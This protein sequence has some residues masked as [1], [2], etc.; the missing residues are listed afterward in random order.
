MDKIRRKEEKRHKRGSDHASANDFAADSFSSLLLASEKKQP[1]DDLIG[2]GQGSKP[3]ALPEGTIRL[4]REGWEEVR[5]PP[6]STAP[7]RPDE[8]LVFCFLISVFCIFLIRIGL[9]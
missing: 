1:F 6:T 9:F 8:K 5:I 4:N 2:A 7:M 3:R